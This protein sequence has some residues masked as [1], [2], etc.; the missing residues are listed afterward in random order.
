MKRI[1]GIF[2]IL[3][4][5]FI[6]SL[7][8]F[9]LKGV[10]I[11]QRQGMPP[12]KDGIATGS[13]RTVSFKHSLSQT[14]IPKAE[15]ISGI[16]LFIGK[17]Q[18]ETKRPFYLSIKQDNKVLKR[19]TFYTKDI[20]SA[21]LNVFYFPP[22]KV[23]K[24]TEHKIELSVGKGNR[25]YLLVRKVNANAYMNGALFVN[26]RQFEEDLVFQTYYDTPTWNLLTSKISPNPPLVNLVYTIPLLELFLLL[27]SGCI[28]LT[29]SQRPTA[30]N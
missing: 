18:K 17:P 25:Y 8:L 9:P 14:F 26:D 23:S 13:A 3:N 27:V 12:F 10:D 28:F 7:A 5:M 22:I 21:G 20:K 29:N 16:G 11:A 30:K 4:I 15:S 2:G 19:I 24:G 6:A 1:L